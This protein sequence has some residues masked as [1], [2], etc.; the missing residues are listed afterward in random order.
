MSH[1]EI[2]A[3]LHRI[4][5]GESDAWSILMEQAYANLLQISRQ[6]RSL[7]QAELHPTYDTYAVLNEAFSSLYDSK[8]VVWKDRKHFYLTVAQA[9]RYVI[10]VYHRNKN[11]LKRGKG[12]VRIS[13]KEA[14]PE[15]IFD[16]EIQDQTSALDIA[17]DILAQTNQRAWEGVMLRFYAGLKE[18]EIA[19]IQHVSTRTVIR[20]WVGARALMA[21]VLQ[22]QS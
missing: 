18:A 13:E 7:K 12:F 11:S 10:T 4:N 20:D 5:H 21:S 9:C 3:L 2:T 8:Q 14:E 15:A 19:K 16:P 6:V 1:S 17:L 22:E